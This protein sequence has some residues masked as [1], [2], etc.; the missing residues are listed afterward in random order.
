MSLERW[1][2]NEIWNLPGTHKSKYL[3]YQLLKQSF[4]VD[5]FCYWH[6]FSSPLLSFPLLSVPPPPS[7]FP[8]LSSSL[9]PFSALYILLEDIKKILKYIFLYAYITLKSTLY[10]V[11]N[12]Y[13][14]LYKFHFQRTLYVVRLNRWNIGRR[15]FST[16]RLLL[17]FKIFMAYVFV[18]VLIVVLFIFVRLNYCY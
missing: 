16:L 7:L 1:K 4:S 11:Y 9:P 8:S 6:I 3:I 17:L 2:I 13:F 12:V 10:I 5:A 15:L 14:F 18:T